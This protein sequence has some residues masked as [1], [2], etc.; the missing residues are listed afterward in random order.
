[1]TQ[2]ELRREVNRHWLGR[3]A[4][5]F[6]RRRGRSLLAEAVDAEVRAAAAGVATAGE[7]REGAAGQRAV[8]RHLIV[9]A[10]ETGAALGVVPTRHRLEQ[11]AVLPAVPEQPVVGADGRSDGLAALGGRGAGRAGRQATA[12]GGE[13]AT[14]AGAEQVAAADDIVA[15]DAALLQAAVER[16]V[17]GDVVA[18]ANDR[19]NA[20]WGALGGGVAG[21]AERQRPL[22]AA[23]A[24]ADATRAEQAAQQPSLL[25][26][27][28]PW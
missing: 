3:A 24:G 4:A 27:A 8:G 16:A 28:P 12:G 19:A 10:E 7:A 25:P 14:A 21:G 26:Q 13:A 20:R 17:G 5:Q 18:G 2:P 6:G 23:I 9:A 1:M 15:A 22:G 11:A